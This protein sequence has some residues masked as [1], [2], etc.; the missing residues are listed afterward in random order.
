MKRR[1][2]FLGVSE[3]FKLLHQQGRTRYRAFTHG[4]NTVICSQAEENDVKRVKRVAK[5]FKWV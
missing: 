1:D 4:G 5:R 3:V 2:G